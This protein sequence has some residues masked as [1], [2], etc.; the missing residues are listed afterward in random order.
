MCVVRCVHWTVPYLEKV[1]SILLPILL[2]MDGSKSNC[3]RVIIV[4]LTFL[5]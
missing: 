1:P 2:D 4:C 5:Y 3:K